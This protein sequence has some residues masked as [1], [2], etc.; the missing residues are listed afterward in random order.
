[1]KKNKTAGKWLG[2]HPGPRDATQKEEIQNLTLENGKYPSHTLNDITIM[3]KC[4]T[5]IPLKAKLTLEKIQN[6]CED[7][8]SSERPCKHN[9]SRRL[10]TT[11]VREYKDL[12]FSYFRYF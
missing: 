1:M 9:R 4:N 8:A 7:L 3:H 5:I 6:E 2:W 12:T 10:H 11:E